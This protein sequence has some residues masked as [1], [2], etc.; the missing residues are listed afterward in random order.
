MINA[1]SEKGF[2]YPK[3]ISMLHLSLGFGVIAGYLRENSIEVEIHDLDRD[4]SQKVMKEEFE[5]FF[6]VNTVLDYIKGRENPQV[7]GIFNKLLEGIDIESFDSVGVSIGAD[8][9]LMQIHAG[10]ML[11]V[12]VKRVYGKTVFVGGN[13][14]S[15]L[16]IFKDVFSELM[17]AALETLPYIIKGAGERAIFEIITKLNQEESTA[18]EVKGL[19][20]VEASEICANEEFRPEIVRPDWDG[21]E[22][23]CYYRYM[24]DDGAAA[25]GEKAL[26]N[27]LIHFYKWPGGFEGSPG[28]MV[29]RYNKTRNKGASPRLIIPYIF[30]YNC[31]FNCAFCTQS[32]IE[33]NY[34]IGGDPDK[35]FE[36]IV[37]LSQ[38]Y[39]SNYFY[40]VN[41]SF[42]FSAKFVDKFCQRVISEGFKFHW[43]DCG[44]FNNM[45]YD[46]LKQMK[47]AGCVKLTFGFETG[48]E[49]L[50]KLINKQL[51][52]EE[53]ERVL[54]WCHELGIWADIEIIVGLPQESDE[55]FEAT[56]RYIERNY[57]FINYIWTNEYFVVPNSLIGRYPERYGIE[58]IRDNK[59]YRSI[60]DHNLMFL[61]KKI[62]KMTFN[63]RLYG[64]NEIGG[65]NYGKIMEDNRT[66]ISRM[67]QMQKKEFA[68]ASK[69]YRM[70]CEGKA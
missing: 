26:A 5:C 13:N 42:N 11:G 30:N 45:T 20:R 69:L 3:A 64:Y 10:L 41:N 62:S 53:S 2:H 9:S 35:V 47:E 17:E 1:P 39:D 21:L 48:S 51:D 34:I 22:L 4:L 40:F 56:L 24:A 37:H 28:E 57:D 68:E 25:G 33:R 52:I 44:R 29:N 32:D 16:Y 36:D 43:A 58:L 54:R 18:G 63:T 60:M 14:V 15:F 8:Y 65:R 49:K 50:L 12:F 27:N 6:E 23:D 31:P 59:P 67:N 7:D 70:L 66:R 38:K 19:M 46:K 61:R 55:D